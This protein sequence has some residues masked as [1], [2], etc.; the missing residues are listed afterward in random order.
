MKIDYELIHNYYEDKLRQHG[1]TAQGMDWKNEDT[2]Y[3][4]FEN[5]IKY[6]NFN[7]APSI[8]DVGCGAAELNHFLLKRSLSFSYKG[9]DIVQDMVDAV[10]N[11]FGAGT[12]FQGNLLEMEMESQYDYVVASGTFN[13]RLNNDEEEW[14]I[15]FFK[16]LERMFACCNKAII[17]NCMSQFVDWRYERLYYVNI[18][19]FTNYIVN[20]LSRKF[21]VDHSYPLYECTYVVY[22][23]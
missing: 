15:F 5:I 10:N 2:Q 23:Q 7:N 21:I 14:R 20:N 12:A 18:N 19:D 8:L 4:R 1:P 9:L 13:A 22:K 6:I 11:R 3:L 17:F 16:N